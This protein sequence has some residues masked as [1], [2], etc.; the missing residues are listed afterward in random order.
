ML[1]CGTAVRSITPDYPVALGGYAARWGKK[2]VGVHDDIFV[3][4]F[5]LT[6]ETDKFLLI[7][8]DV[9]GLTEK[10]L[11]P[12]RERIA[13]ELGILNVSFSATHTHSAPHT[14]PQV[15]LPQDEMDLEWVEALRQKLFEVAKSATDALFPAALGYGNAT[16]PEIAHNRRKGQTIT[17]PALSVLWFQDQAGNVRG[18]LLSYTCHCTILDGNSFLV[19]SDYP[20]SIYMEMSKKYPE[21]VCAFA[22]GCAGDIN[23]GY[24]SDAS[25]LG[26][27]MSIRTFET[28]GKIGRLLASR[29]IDTI[30]KADA[31]E[32]LTV[33]METH[34]V[35]LPLRQTLPTEDEIWAQIHAVDRDTAYCGDPERRRTLRL[36]K[37]YLQSLVLRLHGLT[38]QD[39]FMPAV[40]VFFRIGGRIYIT[41]PGEL[42]A[43]SGLILK[44]RFS[45]HFDPVVLGYSNGYVGYLPPASAM[46]AGG[47]EAETSVFAN[48]A[49]EMLID[50]ISNIRPF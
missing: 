17:D 30:E 49:A 9:E 13:K 21:A 40:V 42:F 39:R 10:L 29:A 6:D 35:L 3:K 34:C 24:S 37:I 23:I 12:V 32:D 27:A 1:Y 5:F 7:F 46:E 28:A 16:V 20:G 11:A 8:A 38:A 25:A 15:Q 22:N 50:Q 41:V 43:E 33:Q 4:A 48:H 18:I 26:E 47:Y 44:E 45:A 31:K 2:S 19:S 14:F 36:R